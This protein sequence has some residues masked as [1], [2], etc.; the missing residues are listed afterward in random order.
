MR[1]YAPKR[2]SHCLWCLKSLDKA[3]FS[4]LV[5]H[6]YLCEEHEAKLNV[7]SKTIMI[8]DHVITYFHVYTPEMAALLFRYKEHG[9]VL[10]SGCLF[11]SQKK[12]LKQWLKNST[13]VFVPSA[14]R[15]TNQRGFSPVLLALEICG[16][17]PINLLI[18]TTE[19]DQ[20]AGNRNQ[21]KATQFTIDV[22]QRLPTKHVTL[23][24]DTLTTGHSLLSCCALLQNQGY[25]VRLIV[26]A[27]H[28]SWI[29]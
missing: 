12:V 25:E 13:A 6:D 16:I 21:R 18:K 17:T 7:S 1:Q 9:D 24:D 26:F 11:Y 22:S 29:E 2:Q 15:K 5:R 27:L 14:T 20:K 28:S 4:F 3:D 8:Q 10:L 23:F 19:H